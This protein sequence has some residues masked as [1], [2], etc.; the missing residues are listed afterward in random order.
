MNSKWY[1][2]AKIG[3]SRTND[4]EPWVASVARDSG[5]VVRPLIIVD[6]FI[7]YLAEQL[8]MHGALAFCSPIT[9]SYNII[10]L[11][12]LHTVQTH[13]GT[14]FRPIMSVGSQVPTHTF[15]SAFKREHLAVPPVFGGRPQGFLEWR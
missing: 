11:P 10:S 6:R 8:T 14:V 7:S 3:G 12:L 13:P 4:L 2:I 1:I 15:G 9:V 5:L